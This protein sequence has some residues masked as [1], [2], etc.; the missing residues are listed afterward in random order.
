M[1]YELHSLTE[2]C[3][4]WQ[5]YFKHTVIACIS[6]DL[7]GKLC[8]K[9]IFGQWKFPYKN[10][11]AQS[12]K[13]IKEVLKN[14]VGAILVVNCNWK[15]LLVQIISLHNTRND[16]IIVFRKYLPTIS[17]CDLYRI[18]WKIW[19][20]SF[21]EQQGLNCFKR[22]SYEVRQSNLNSWNSRCCLLSS[23]A[24][25]LAAN[26]TEACQYKDWWWKVQ[27]GKCYYR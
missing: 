26:A 2:K 17:S 15:S 1:N 24:L 13:K 10:Y 8:E 21:Q 14:S 3:E 25:E 20:V 22:R 27:L 7:R 4:N 6:S 19:S 11:V 16:I 12:W 23:K 5:S 9:K 18:K